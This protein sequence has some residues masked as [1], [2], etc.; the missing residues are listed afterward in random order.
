MT[1][2]QVVE[3]NPS[4][5]AKLYVAILTLANVVMKIKRI[6]NNMSRKWKGHTWM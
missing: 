1:L 5:N 3:K 6:N 2:C 4:V